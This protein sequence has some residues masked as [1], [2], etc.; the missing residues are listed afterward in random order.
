MPKL[1]ELL[2]SVEVIEPQLPNDEEALQGEW[3]LEWM[4]AA[5]NKMSVPARTCVI[6]GNSLTLDGDNPL[7]FV[8]DPATTPKSIDMTLNLHRQ[9]NPPG[10]GIYTLAGDTFMLCFDKDG[11]KDRPAT[12][13]TKPGSPIAVMG[14][15]RVAPKKVQPE[16]SGLLPA[17]TL[18]PDL[19]VLVQKQPEKQLA[20]DKTNKKAKPDAKNDRFP[21]G[22]QHD[23]GE[24]EFGTTLKHAFRIANTSTVPLYLVS[25]RASAGCITG[26]VNK[27]VLQPK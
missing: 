21:D 4:E 10:K 7:F 25:V 11:A 3:K 20:S 17:G 6:R 13:Q 26:I 2:P 16:Q 23:F 24:V 9:H 1:S 14:F 19:N 15:K 18:T 5:G 22:R 27:Q 8:L 12:F